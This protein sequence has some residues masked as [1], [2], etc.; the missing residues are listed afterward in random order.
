MTTLF[1]TTRQAAVAPRWDLTHAAS[2]RSVVSV[3]GNMPAGGKLGR[4]Q[5]RVISGL[6][7]QDSRAARTLEFRIDNGRLSYMGALVA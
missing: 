6:H 3:V 5:A 2:H 7:L 4:R 1:A